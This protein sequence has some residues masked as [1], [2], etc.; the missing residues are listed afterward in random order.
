MRPSKERVDRRNACHTRVPRFMRRERER[1][2][3]C[4]HAAADKDMR[5]AS[6][7]S[8]WSEAQAIV[9]SQDEGK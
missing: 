5:R 9:S 6:D 1:E 2:K 3:T 8:R 7:Q 4:K